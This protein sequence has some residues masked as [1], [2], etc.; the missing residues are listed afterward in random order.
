MSY[1]SEKSRINCD[2]MK[3]LDYFSLF[4]F[5]AL[6]AGK[7]IPVPVIQFFVGNKFVFLFMEHFYLTYNAI[8]AY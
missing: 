4:L 5:L 7:S 8:F 3:P 1:C 6:F 2:I